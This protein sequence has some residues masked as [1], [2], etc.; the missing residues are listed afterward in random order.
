[1]HVRIQSQVC[2]PQKP[3]RLKENSLNSYGAKELAASFRT[4]RGN[5]I[6]IAKDIPEDKY[7]FRATPDTRTVGNLLV[8]IAFSY[9][10]QYTIHGKDKLSTIRGFNFPAMLAG[11]IAEEKTP[12]TK[13]PIIELL[14]SNGEKFATWL[15]GLSEEFLAE[16]VEMPEGAVPASKSRLEMILGVKEHEMH[17]R[18]QLMM[19]QRMIGI[20]PH[21]T[22]QMQERMAAANA[23]KN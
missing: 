1:M 2:A 7:D 11:L 9:T 23:G 13:A 19:I 6:A 15:D 21:L 22:R 20:V 17:H 3:D 18:G 12:R 16:R 10:F 4:V 14:Q 5:T 8:H